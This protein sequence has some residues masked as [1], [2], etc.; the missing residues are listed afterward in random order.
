MSSIICKSAWSNK[1][2]PGY[3]IEC[4]ALAAH[5]DFYA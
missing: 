3:D 1:I 5:L 4:A 2:V